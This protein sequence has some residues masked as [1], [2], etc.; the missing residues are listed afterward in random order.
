MTDWADKTAI[1]VF[2]SQ[3]GCVGL[4]DVA[5]ALRQARLK[6]L[7]EAEKEIRKWPGATDV[8]CLSVIRKLKEKKA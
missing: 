2:S 4:I 1:E 5:D 6:G 7:K 8:W 3:D